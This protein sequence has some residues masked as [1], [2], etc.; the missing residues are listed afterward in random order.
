[1]Y[2][3]FHRKYL[4]RFELYSNRFDF[5]YELLAK[6]LRSGAKPLEMPVSYVSRDFKEG[7]KIR[8]FKDPFNW[9]VAI[10]RY[11]FSPL[12]KKASKIY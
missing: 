3:I 12:K 7:K 5:D 10:L 2:K 8:P 4:S 1:M 11:R 6:L 9:V